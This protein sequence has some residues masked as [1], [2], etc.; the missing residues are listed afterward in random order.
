MKERESSSS[1]ER[2]KIKERV[3]HVEAT[4]LDNKHEWEVFRPYR[5][6]SSSWRTTRCFRG[7]SFMLRQWPNGKHARLLCGRPGFDSRN[8][9]TMFFQHERRYHPWDHIV[10][11]K[12][13]RHNLTKQTFLKTVSSS[14]SSRVKGDGKR[15]DMINLSNLAILKNCR[16]QNYSTPWGGPHST[17]DS[18][19]PS[20]P[21][22]PG[23]ILSIPEYLQR[24][25][26]LPGFIDSTLLR[27]SG[28]CK[29]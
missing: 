16:R 24:N 27:E 13:A 29:A 2:L 4:K 12:H 19:P 5:S 9:S 18:H 23:S 8:T 6:P 25:S 11:C 1:E 17:V 15:P 20:Y 28:Q 22:S 3:F 10:Y 21:A 14:I 7:V 26:M